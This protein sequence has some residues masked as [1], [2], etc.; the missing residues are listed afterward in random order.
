MDGTEDVAAGPAKPV[1]DDEGAVT[2]VLDLT[3]C[4]PHYDQFGAF[5]GP[6]PDDD[7]AAT[8]GMTIKPLLDATHESLALI[9]SSV[10]S[11]NA[12]LQQLAAFIPSPT[13][14]GENELE[15]LAESVRRLDETFARINPD[16]DKEEQ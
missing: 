3:V 10:G 16:K 14:V 6:V 12:I 9:V 15:R 8:G 11:I 7:H 1:L 2:H 4:F 5:G 13:G